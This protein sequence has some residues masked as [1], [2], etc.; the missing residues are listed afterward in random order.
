MR[1]ILF[2]FSLSCILLAS[3]GSP[4]NGDSTV[5]ITP[6]S[7]TVKLMFIHHSSGQNWLST[8]NGNLGTA[9]N[10]NHYY[11]T[12]S[13]YGWDSQPG[14]NLGDSTDTVNW[15]AWFNDAKMPGVYANTFMNTYANTIAA[16]SGENQVI[17][18]K[19][20]FPN[21]EVGSSI[22]DEKAIYS[23]LLPYFAAHPDKL[24][25]LVT[26]PGEAS[27]SSYALTKSLCDWLVDEKT[28]WL[29][30][31][32]QKNVAAFDFYCVLSETDS[33]H[34]VVDG[35]VQHAYSAS[36]DGESPYHVYGLSTDDHPN[37][38]GNQKA[39]E[40]FLP[41]LNAMYNRWQ[42]SR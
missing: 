2:I 14:D 42:A 38:T 31:Y 18:F 24:F 12:E 17:M 9:L 28:G 19:S 27:V 10:A 22:D 29:K 7:T 15:P 5:S 37:S 32:T 3:C 11:V 33:H 21:S 35:A 16:P 6:P 26:P 8:G 30:G 36:Y 41:W 20:C 13:D 1:K 25:I 4:Q 23:G 39:S 40:E 34:R